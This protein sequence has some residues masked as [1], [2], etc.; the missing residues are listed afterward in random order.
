MLNMSKLIDLKPLE[1]VWEANTRI[2]AVW[3]FGSAQE[4]LLR[5]GSDVDI[6]ILFGTSPSLDDQLDLLAQIQKTLQVEDIDLVILNEANPILAFE[7][8]SG[9]LLFCR[10]TGRRAE[11]VSLVAREYEDGMALWQRGLAYRREI[12]R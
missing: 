5:S 1:I 9:R 4:G 3:V 10:N 6:A 2:I 7:A 11:F 12:G 8:V